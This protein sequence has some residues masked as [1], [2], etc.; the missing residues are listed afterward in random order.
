MALN[1]PTLN[2]HAIF[3]TISETKRVLSSAL[4]EKTSIHHPEIGLRVI[5]IPIAL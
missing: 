3:S 2:I 1:L 5:M 4:L